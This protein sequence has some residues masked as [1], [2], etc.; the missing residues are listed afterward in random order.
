MD[1][2]PVL[3]SQFYPRAG[4]RDATRHKCQ[5]RGPDSEK[6]DVF[7]EWHVGGSLLAFRYMIPRFA[8]CGRS[9]FRLPLFPEPDFL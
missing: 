2:R 9:L 5:K 3:R 6:A 1:D 8:V 4:L 7:E